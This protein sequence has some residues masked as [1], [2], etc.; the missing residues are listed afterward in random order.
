MSAEGMIVLSD[1]VYMFLCVAFYYRMAERKTQ[2]YQIGKWTV[3]V[4]FLASP[5]I[6]QCLFAGTGICRLAGAGILLV[7]SAIWLLCFRGKEY[8]MKTIWLKHGLIIFMLLMMSVS[9]MLTAVIL[10]EAGERLHTV[11]IW[12]L[13]VLLYAAADGSLLLYQ[14]IRGRK[15][16]AQDSDMEAEAENQVQGCGGMEAAAEHLPVQHCDRD[17]TAAHP[18]QTGIGVEAERFGYRQAGMLAGIM[19]CYGLVTFI[20]LGSRQMPQTSMEIVPDEAGSHEIILD[21]GSEQ[22]IHSLYMHLGHM[23]DRVI[24]VSYYDEQQA[25]WIPIEEEIELD[26]NYNWNEVEIDTTLRYLG[27]VSRSGRAVYNELVLLDGDGELLL[28]ANSDE[29]PLLFDEQELF[30]EDIT[31][32]YRT[33]FDEVYYAGSAYEFLNG[34]QMFETTHPPMGKILIA[35]GELLFGVNPFGWRFVC[36]VFGMLMLPLIC[37]FLYRMFRSSSLALIGTVLLS[38]DFMH[39]TLSRIATLDTIV[40]FFILS[41]FAVMWRVLDMAEKE[42]QEERKRPSL[43]LTAVMLVCAALTGMGVATKWTGFYAM[44]GIA[45]CFLWFIGSRSVRLKKEGKKAG[46]CGWMLGEGIVIFGLLPMGI[47]VLSFLPQCLAQGQ[48]NLWKVMWD[49]SLFMLNFHSDIVFEHPYE[50]PWYTWAWMR[51]PLFDSANIMDNTACSVVVTMGNPVIWWCGLASCFHM[52]YR[53]LFRKDKRAGYLA[54]AYLSMYVPWFFV[55]RT[56]FIYQYYGSS[57]FMICMLAYSLYLLG[58]KHQKLI[59]VFLEAAL[60]IFI[61]FY[62]AISGYAVSSYHLAIYLEWLR[63]WKFAWI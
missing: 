9:G 28:P 2:M 1:V 8:R 53:T 56:V 30:P 5:P 58:R 14:V 54:F 37:W 3:P 22:E 12:S 43:C 35:I 38:L 10:P 32:Y 60:L 27:I 51:T 39:F 33:M 61:L 15:T 18:A 21:M 25:Q 24:A 45:V 11:Q 63:S 16:A 42:I 59:P 31:Y 46:Y 55:R 36:A 13:L 6:W 7:L 26:S 20:G 52:F 47:Y 29:Y 23:L 50:S 48:D 57:L 34:M 17:E 41:M 44:A 4:L 62:P 19:L 49:S 40:A